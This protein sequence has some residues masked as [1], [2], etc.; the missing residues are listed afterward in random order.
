MDLFFLLFILGKNRNVF[1]NLMQERPHT[2][3]G[4]LHD[5]TSTATFRVKVI[6]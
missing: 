3:F 6:M 4:C 1:Q 2:C 5:N